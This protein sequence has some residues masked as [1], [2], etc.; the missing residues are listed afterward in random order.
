MTL[1]LPPPVDFSKTSRDFIDAFYRAS[2]IDLSDLE[3]KISALRGY[4][5]SE[6]L[7]TSMDGDE[8]KDSELR[9]LECY[10]LIQAGIDE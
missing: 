9:A 6:M 10:F 8:S 2:R 7:V 3:D 1:D 5:G 4:F